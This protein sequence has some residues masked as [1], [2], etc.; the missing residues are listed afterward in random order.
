[1]GGVSE[2]AF[3]HHRGKNEEKGLPQAGVVRAFKE[4]LG[5]GMRL[6]DDAK[7][8]LANAANAYLASVGKRAGM[9]AM[10]GKRVTIHEGDVHKAVE[11]LRA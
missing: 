5:E 7:G 2:L 10:A 11:T 9:M 3:H 1:M 8:A 4:H 6:S